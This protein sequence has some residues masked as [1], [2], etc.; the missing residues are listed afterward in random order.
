MKRKTLLQLFT[1]YN[2][3]IKD[4]FRIMKI[5]LFLL[6]VS[7]FQLMA[8]ETEAQNVVINIQQNKLSIK[9][10]I[11]EIEKQTEYLVVFRDKDVNVNKVISFQKRSGK[12][13]DYLDEIYKDTNISYVFENNYIDRKSVV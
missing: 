13:S 8:T 6:F 5:S 12:V 4:F 1:V 2:N 9:Q 3:S 10:L 7:V 11:K